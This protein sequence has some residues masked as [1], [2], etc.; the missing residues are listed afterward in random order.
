MAEES[1]QTFLTIL[2]DRDVPYDREAIKA[3]FNDPNS[4]TAIQAWI[5]EY[6]T[7]ETLLTRD[8]AAL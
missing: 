8:E 3:A 1:Y 6:L 5:Q 4:Q 7:P 2:R